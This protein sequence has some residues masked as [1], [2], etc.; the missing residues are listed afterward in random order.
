MPD[1]HLQPINEN[2]L[3]ELSPSLV[4]APKNNLIGLRKYT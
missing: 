3:D 4:A 2:Q 1:S